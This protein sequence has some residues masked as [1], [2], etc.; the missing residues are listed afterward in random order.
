M[1]EEQYSSH[2]WVIQS[3]LMLLQVG[4]GLNFMSPTPLFPVIMDDY[5]ISRSAVSLLVSATIIV[6]TIGLLPGGLLI[7]KMG[8]RRSMALAGF[9][10]SAHLLT[11]LTDS[12]ILLVMIRL[13]FGIGV[14]ITIP[15]TSAITMEW[16]KPGELPLL[17]GVNEAGRA[18]G[19]AL[20]VFI[21]VPITNII[22]WHMTL[23]S[24]GAIPLVGSCI[25]IMGGRSSNRSTNDGAS[26][27]VR[28]NVP[29]M[30]N[31]NTLLLAAGM[32]GAFAVFIGFSSWLPAYYNEIR[33]ISLGKA[34]SIVAVMPLMSAALNPVSGFIQSKLG[35]RKPML[36]LSGLLLPIFAL[37]SFLIPSQGVAIICVMGLGATFSIFIVAA[38]TIPMELPGVSASS[39]GIVTAAVLTMGNLAGVISPI[40][41]GTLTDFLGSYITPFSILALAP[42]TLVVA[43]MLLPETGYRGINPNHRESPS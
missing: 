43:G 4:M 1:Q 39:V 36:T 13:M 9:L 7:A 25:W 14:A 23:F 41:V 15:A 37:G 18:L 24:F 20:G 8:S 12:F 19:V 26:F 10:M 27:S 30:L 34:S 40:F 29:L 16:F 32:A 22:G 6:M 33:G 3:M 2:R 31:R 21:A 42:L 35:R 5:E 28:A 11:P 17:N 38:L